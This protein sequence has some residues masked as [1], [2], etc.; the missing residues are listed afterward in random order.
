MFVTLKNLSHL[1]L[2][3]NRINIIQ[4]QTFKGLGELRSL[5]LEN[6]NI[7]NIEL[8]GI[9]SKCSINLRG[10]NIRRFHDFHGL[11]VSF[12]QKDVYCLAVQGNQNMSVPFL[13]Y[14]RIG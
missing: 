3:N 9:F 6:N 7:V 12:G 1:S 14:L 10:N 4:P 11:P 5:N 8:I 2:A 13:A